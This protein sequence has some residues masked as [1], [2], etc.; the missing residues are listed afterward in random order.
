MKKENLGNLLFTGYNEGKRDKEHQHSY[1]GQ[2]V[3][4]ETWYIEGE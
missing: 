1:K 4:E 2:G 3:L